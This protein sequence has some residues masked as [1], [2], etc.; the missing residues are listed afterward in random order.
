MFLLLI[1][2]GL[3][4]IDLVFAQQYYT[5][6]ESTISVTTNKSTYAMS[7]TITVYGTVSRII[8]NTSVTISISNPSGNV[9]IIHQIYP[10]TDGIFSITFQNTCGPLWNLNGDY[11]VNAHYG[12]YTKASSIFHYSGCSSPTSNSTN[13]TNANETTSSSSCKT[14]SPPQTPSPVWPP[15]GAVVYG[16][17]FTYEWTPETSSCQPITYTIQFSADPTF[18]TGVQT[19][20]GTLLT[21]MLTMNSSGNATIY[22]RVY[23]QNAAGSSPPSKISGLTIQ[24]PSTDVRP[25]KAIP[26]E[27]TLNT[28]STLH[29]VKYTLHFNFPG[30]RFSIAKVVGGTFD[31]FIMSGNTVTFNVNDLEPQQSKTGLVAFTFED[32][33]VKPDRKGTFD[34]TVTANGITKSITKDPGLEEI[35]IAIQTVHDGFNLAVSIYNSTVSCFNLDVSDMRT[36]VA[37]LNPKYS[38]KMNNCSTHPERVHLSASGELEN[39]VFSGNDMD[40]G[41]SKTKNVDLT[42]FVPNNLSNGLH[43]FTVKGDTM[44]DIFGYNWNVTYSSGTGLYQV[45]NNVVI[46]EFP[47]SA[48]LILF[49]S[50]F[51]ILMFF[52]NRKLLA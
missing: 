36:I 27:F 17:V 2:F 15:N 4:N 14:F 25:I 48:T 19:F 13:V 28:N 23:A 21:N 1:V 16:N 30:E 47:Q 46:P 50:T 34:I 33:E 41:N 3:T 24:I 26:Y 9:V 8:N 40:I 37:P 42:L 38:V 52:H 35:D 43:A 6:V 44:L 7:D 31:N 12:N 11:A 29:N 39:Y 18:N 20:G 5:M 51:S 22:W 32:N 49:V 10:T 45:Q